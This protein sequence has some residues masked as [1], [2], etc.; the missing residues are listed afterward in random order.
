MTTAIAFNGGAYGTYL[1]WCLTTLS[2]TNNIVPPFSNIGNSHKFGG[3]HLLNINGWK[4]YKA[5]NETSAQF[6]RLHPKTLQ[7]E[8]LS[9]NMDYL[10]DTADSVVY[11]YPDKESILLALNNFTYK[12]WEDWWEH[13]FRSVLDVNKIYNNWPVNKSTEISD[14]PNWIKREFLSF[15]LMPAW[16][17]QVEWDHLDTW[18]H[19]NCCVVTINQLLYNFENTIQRIKAHCNLHFEKDVAELVPFHQQNLKLQ[20]YISQDQICNQIVNDVVNHRQVEWE[21]LTLTSESWVQWELRNRG[22]EIRCD[23][24]D[25]FPTNSIQLRELLYPV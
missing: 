12:I 4:N 17:A 15:Y 18:Q 13:S 22:F 1:E 24:L 20:K 25:M 8:S 6:V 10:C 3:H 16:F 23:G 19:P 5:A 2:S 21:E 11:L 9:A 14:I 7:T